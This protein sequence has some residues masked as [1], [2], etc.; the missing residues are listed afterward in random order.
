MGDLNK[1]FREAKTNRSKLEA[2]QMI[3]SL[4]EDPETLRIQVEMGRRRSFHSVIEKICWL[5]LRRQYPELADK[6]RISIRKNWTVGWCDKD[7]NEDLG[8]LDT[9]FGAD[10][11]PEMP[12]ELLDFLR[13]QTR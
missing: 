12:A 3:V 11:Q 4:Q 8:G 6:P 7:D 13:S 9:L 5:E 1:K 2:L 10:D